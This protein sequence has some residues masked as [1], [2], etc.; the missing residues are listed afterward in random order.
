MNAYGKTLNAAASKMLQQPLRADVSLDRFLFMCCTGRPAYTEIR[1]E[2]YI[3]SLK[4]IEQ[5]QWDSDL[6]SQFGYS[7]ISMV[8]H[9]TV[10]QEGFILSIHKLCCSFVDALV[11][12]L[13]RIKQNRGWY[14]QYRQRLIAPLPIYAEEGSRLYVDA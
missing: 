4:K 10:K 1:Q 9:G 2:T 13:F 14:D 3:A 5:P 12:R 8:N 11:K 7:A 6:S